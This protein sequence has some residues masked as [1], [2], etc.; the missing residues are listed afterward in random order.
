MRTGIEQQHPHSL[1]PAKLLKPQVPV[2]SAARLLPRLQPNR[3]GDWQSSLM[4]QRQCLVDR[5]ARHLATA[6][7]GHPLRVGIDG[8]CGAGKSTFARELTAALLARGERAI[9]LDSDGFHHI[10]AIRYRQGRDSARG[11][12]E[13]AYNFDALAEMVLR[14]L[15]PRGAFV[16]ATRVHD[17]RTDEVLR[18]DRATADRSSI[19]I[20]DCTFVQRGALRELWD[21]VIFLEVDR[22]VGAV[23]GIE[24][25]AHQFDGREAARAAYASRYMRACDIYVAEERPAER[26][27]I[28][29][30]NNDVH[31]PR[32]IRAAWAARTG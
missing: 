1:R 7:L 24:R 2:A 28:V 21:E 20:F 27:T 25:D 17:L 18:H 9:H 15:G 8:L 4:T 22:E 30:D 10:R 26:A 11:Y 5:I 12:Y 19:V 29:I 23:R 3:A 14:P 31:K 16:Y 13:D 6:R 32:L